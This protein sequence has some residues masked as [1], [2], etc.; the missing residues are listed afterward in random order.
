MVTELGWKENEIPGTYDAIHQALLTGLL[1]N[2]GCKSDESGYYLGARGIRYLIHPSSPLQKKAGKW[3]MAAEIT[4]TTRLFGRCVARIEA[5]WIEKVGAHLI[6][7]QY[8]DPHW[9]KKVDAGRRLGA[10]DALRRGDQPQA[11]H[12]LRPAGA[13]RGAR[14]LHPP[15]AGRRGD[16]RELRPALA[17]LPAQ[18]EADPRHR[19]DRAQ[20]APAGRAGRRRADFRLLRPHHSRRHP[21]RRRLRPLAQGGRAGE[22]PPAVPGQGRPD[23][24]LGGGRHHRGLPAP[25]QGRRRRLSRSPTISSRARRAT[26]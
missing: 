24:P 17:L 9:E 21:Q 18:P 3:I 13:G 25:P 15:G 7:R 12:P 11:A 14:D 22:S 6:K 10:H 4:E 5:D 19:E 23:A 20:A 2:I 8:F 16:R 1:G 26:A